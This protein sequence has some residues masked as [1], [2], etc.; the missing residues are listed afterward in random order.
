MIKQIETCKLKFYRD[1]SHS[2]L[3]VSMAP[4]NITD[5]VNLTSEQ[6]RDLAKAATDMAET[7][8]AQQFDM[9]YDKEQKEK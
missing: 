4:V 5:Y 7:L 9:D 6:L 3:L 2:V 8:E 1:T